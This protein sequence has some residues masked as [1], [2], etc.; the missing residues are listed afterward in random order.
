M[1]TKFTYTGIRVKDL[2][3]SVAFYTKVLG[4]KDLGR[5]TVDATKGR[6]ASLAT[7]EDGFVLEMKTPTSRWAYIA[8]P[9]GIWIELFV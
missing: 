8:D 6:S 1:K 5:S 3:A 7:E 9:N 4:M 2:E